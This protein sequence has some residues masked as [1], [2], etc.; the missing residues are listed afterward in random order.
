MEPCRE[1]YCSSFMKRA[2]FKKFL[3]VELLYCMLFS[4]DI[5]GAVMHLQMFSHEQGETTTVSNLHPLKAS[6]ECLH[7]Y[8]K[9]SQPCVLVQVCPMTS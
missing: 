2:D 3:H 1:S 9:H 5:S 4:H 6:D 7:P 8:A